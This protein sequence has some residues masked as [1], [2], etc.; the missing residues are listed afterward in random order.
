MESD[1][2]AGML[3][4]MSTSAGNGQGGSYAVMLGACTL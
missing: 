4:L 3:W 2:L 1:H